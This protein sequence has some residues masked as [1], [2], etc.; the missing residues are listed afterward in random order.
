MSCRPEDLTSRVSQLCRL[1]CRSHQRR[2]KER[3][4]ERGELWERAEGGRGRGSAQRAIG[5]RGECEQLE[6]MERRGELVES[7]RRG[8][9]KGGSL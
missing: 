6:V 3:G 1:N 7:D 4:G 8:R 2:L 9:G 5:A